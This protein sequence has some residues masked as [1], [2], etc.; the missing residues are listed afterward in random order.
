MLSQ[1]IPY[2]SAYDLFVFAHGYKPSQPE[3]SDL[4][5]CLFLHAG[6]L[7]LFGNMLFLWIYGDNV[8]H[9][10]GR[11]GFLAAYLVTGVVATLFFSLFAGSSMTPLIGASGAISGVLGL[12][13][14]LFPRNRVKVLIMFFPIFFKTIM[15]PARWVLGF[16]LVVDNLLPFLSQA[17]SSVA[18][19]AHI[20][21]FLAGLAIAWAGERAFW[22]WPSSDTFWRPEGRDQTAAGADNGFLLTELREAKKTG[23]MEL[24]VQ[25]LS[26]MERRA[27]AELNPHECVV[28][29][30]CLDQ[31]GHDIAAVKILR[32][33]LTKYAGSDELADVNLLLGFIRLKQGQPTSAY[34]YFLNVLDHNPDPQTAES[35][36]MALL[37]IESDNR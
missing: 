17:S 10:L 1:I 20:G 4:F 18:Y 22:H 31:K 13:F 6:L 26:K 33:C 34:H 12:Y 7:H 28:L 3:F 24:A 5:M 19:G 11:V 36:R 23:D 29:A 35:A 37:R 9:R 21:G 32:I 8:E 16:Y 15:L 2:L 30:N 25:I 27:I 14:L